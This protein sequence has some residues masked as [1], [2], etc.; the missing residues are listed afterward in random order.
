MKNLLFGLFLAAT[1]FATH[2]QLNLT[3]QANLPF[4]GKDLANIGGY[5]DGQGN[6]YALVGTSTGL[7]IVD[8]TSPSLPIEKFTV[9]GPV[10]TWR[11]VKTWSDYAYVTTEGGSSGLQIINLTYLPDSIQVKYWTGTGAIAGQLETIHALH[12]ED[13]HVYLFGSNLA[14]GGPIIANLAD[15]WNPVYVGQKSGSYVHDGYVRNDTLWACHIYD[16]FFSVMN[17]ANKS[18]PPVV[19]QQTTPGQFTHN[20][21]LN[22]EGSVLFTTDE[23]NNSYLTAYDV[24]DVNNIT[25]L[26]RARSQNPASN[27]MV[28]NTHVINDFAVTSWYKDGVVIHDV[29]RPDNPIL[30]GWFDTSPLSGGGSNGCWG[31]YPY[32]PSGTIVASDMEEGLFVLNP[33]Y[34]RGAYL[35]G[36]VTD[37]ISTVPLNNVLVEILTTSTSVNTKL[38]GIYKTGLATSGTFSV[39]FT[40]AGYFTKVINNVSLS[41][42]VLTLLD[43]QLAPLSPPINLSGQVINAFTSAPIANAFVQIMNIAEN[44][45]ATTDV[46]GNFAI[47][48]FLPNNYDVIAGQWGYVTKCVNQNITGPVLIA[49]EPG[50][51]DDFT[52][53][54]NW[55]VT[56]TAS[57]GI[58][59]RGVPVGTT[60]N[61]QP[62]NPGVDISSDCGNQ[63]FV[64]G[65]GGGRAGNDDVDNG[66][67][68]LT[69]PLFDVTG[70]LE[71][72]VYYHRW[73]YN[74]GGTGNPN[75]SL[76][77]K[78]NN[79]TTTAILEIVT[80]NT[81][82]NSSWVPKSF[83]ISDYVI[84]TSTMTVSFYTADLAG[85]GHLVEAGVDEFKVLEMGTEVTEITDNNYLV[86]V[87]P[88]PS[89]GEININFKFNKPIN[90]DAFIEFI[91]VTGQVAKK[92][93]IFNSEGNIK[94]SG[95]AP[96]I[97]FIRIKNGDE[98]STPMKFILT[99]D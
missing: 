55:T 70:Y 11:E 32:L 72:H 52:F 39:R 74:D 26:S 37:S 9:A 29:A 88:N 24:R 16:G 30:V 53:N 14:S 83:K 45:Q 64:T 77:V 42:G 13:A 19:A 80:A 49:L 71:P 3:L 90:H 50:I 68:T 7:S 87:Y 99:S 18:N 15:P 21:W 54:F 34:I 35:E 8:V 38:T 60:N 82:N 86:S 57:S 20:A 47:N 27:S 6:E 69:S 75:D 5:V 17:V 76:I 65:N 56:G 62:S 46:S 98:F 95:I 41:N 1:A 40:R 84:P 97:Y 85:S 31:V 25:E 78:I 4:P 67:T 61:G 92:H 73:F 23:I 89:N 96:G 63:A 81:P 44:Y 12:I 22:D 33:D 48:N 2:A 58:W 93:Q 66:T 28:H 59:Q 94:S 43:V 51:Y 10:S 36:L 79:G 91:S